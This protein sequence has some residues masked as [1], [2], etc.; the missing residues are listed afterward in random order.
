LSGLAG[1]FLMIMRPT[2]AGPWNIND[3]EIH[4][5][6]MTNV[7][8][9]AGGFVTAP[10]YGWAGQ[11]WRTHRAWASAALV[12]GALCCEPFVLKLI[13]RRYPGDEMVW[14]VEILIGIALAALFLT[15]GV[16]YRRHGNPELGGP[17]A[18]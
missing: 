4:Y 14:P 16:A 1:Y 6:L 13:G 3:H 15:I 8:Y 10:I 5:V 11:R 18:T 12:T 17:T 9:V 7:L 2:G